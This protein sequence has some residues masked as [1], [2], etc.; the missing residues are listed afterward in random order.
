MTLWSALSHC[1]CT[2]RS[3]FP[4]TLDFSS[5][6]DSQS[7]TRSSAMGLKGKLTSR[8]L[9]SEPTAEV[10][11]GGLIWRLNVVH[12]RRTAYWPRAV[13]PMSPEELLGKGPHDVLDRLDQTARILFDVGRHI[14]GALHGNLILDFDAMRALVRLAYEEDR[15]HRRARQRDQARQSTRCRRDFAKERD[16]D[17]LAA[18]GVLIERN[19]H[20]AALPQRT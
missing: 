19:A 14:S 13:A 11:E 7:S 12:R 5:T 15:Q 6:P 9:S 16:E 3:K 18:L 2:T 1:D 4:F 10:G 20:G 17:S 8:I